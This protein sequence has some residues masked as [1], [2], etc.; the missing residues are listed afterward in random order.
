[1][2]F[3][4]LLLV[5]PQYFNDTL[6][7]LMGN[8]LDNFLSKAIS[9]ELSENEEDRSIVWDTMTPHIMALYQLDKQVLVDTHLGSLCKNTLIVTLQTMLHRE[10]HRAVLVKERLVDFV[11][12][13]PWYTTGV[14]QERAMELVSMIRR[15]P[16]IQYQPPSLLNISKAAVSMYYCGLD[17]VMSLSVP[18]LASKLWDMYYDTSSY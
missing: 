6:K 1:M 7:K 10:C 18:E 13:L 17:D 5:S 12:C 11:V 15:S 9:S 14:V 3:S 8:I 4:L 16:D 2:L